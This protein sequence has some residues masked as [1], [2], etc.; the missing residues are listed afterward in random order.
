[1]SSNTEKIIHVVG[2]MIVVFGLVFYFKKTNNQLILQVNEKFKILED[3]IKKQEHIINCLSDK[4]NSMEVTKH[5]YEPP[6]KC[7]NS[8]DDKINAT[9]TSFPSKKQ[10]Q[11]GKQHFKSDINKK[12]IPLFNLDNLQNIGL[13]GLGGV[14]MMGNMP[15]KKKVE[16]NIEELKDESDDEKNTQKEEIKEEEDEEEEEEIY[17]D[18]IYLKRNYIDNIYG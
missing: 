14:V 15:T 18:E 6:E 17:W 1:M 11:S 16:F 7:K 8:F 9:Y 3:Q 13:G 5:R 2:E 12:S 10:T 4:L